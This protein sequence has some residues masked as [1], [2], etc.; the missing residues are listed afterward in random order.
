MGI[1]QH[2]WWRDEAYTWLVVG[3]SRTVGELIANLGFNG[4]PRLYY[5]FAWALHH[6]STHPL[7]L[8]VTNLGFALAAMALVFRSAPLSPLQAVAFS[9]GFYPLYQYGVICRSYSLF[10]FLL[11][12]YCH[13]RAA[14]PKAVSLRL[15][16]LA[17]LAQV[18]LM[19]VGPA[20]VLLTLEWLVVP[21]KQ[22]WRTPQWAAAS[23]V[24]GSIVLS[25]WQ[26]MPDANY[27]HDFE[28]PRVLA[29]FRGFANGFVPNFELSEGRT[30]HVIGLALFLASFGLLWRR[31]TALSAYVLLSGSLAA[32]CAVVYEGYR[33]HHGLYFVFLLAALWHSGTG[34]LRGFRAWLL[35]IILAVQ[36]AG[37]AY[38]LGVDLVRPYSS[39]ALAARFLQD[40]RIDHLPLIGIG[41][42]P[43]DG[44][45]LRAGER[46]GSVTY[47][48]D[49]DHVQP[50]LLSLPDHKIYDPVAGTFERFFK[51]YTHPYFADMDLATLER[52]IR[53]VASH[54][55][56]PVVFVVVGYHVDSLPPLRKLV[57]L[58]EPFDYGERYSIFLYPP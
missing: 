52:S 56:G 12:A 4:H 43:E 11:F 44:H 5:I 7:A 53:G 26:L 8:S 10:M 54:F 36:L 29:T 24:V 34:P 17:A 48:W 23:V 27:S 13:L 6:V 19:S 3:S 21:G 37:G 20:A 41:I 28:A 15:L 22:R 33:W 55:D 39:G 40:R 58:P 46:K 51:H 14:R 18:H 9:L 47:R 2:E 45:P 57:D 16:V 31:W 50:V 35:N 42:W 25:A 30:Q 32:V 49:I 1:I 38:A